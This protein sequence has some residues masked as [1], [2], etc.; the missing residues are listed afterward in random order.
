MNEELEMKVSEPLEVK[1][2]VDSGNYSKF[3]IESEKD[4]IEIRYKTIDRYNSHED[5]IPRGYAKNVYEEKK[6]KDAHVEV[7]I[8]GELFQFLIKDSHRR[9][10][11]YYVVVEHNTTAIEK[12]KRF[13][14]KFESLP[15]EIIDRVWCGSEIVRHIKDYKK[16]NGEIYAIA[17][18]E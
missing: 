11:R 2:S 10:G 7:C 3:K 17:K 12:H 4:N 1:I 8:N 16:D 6:R 5:I 14:E 15:V 18:L 9:R 13:K